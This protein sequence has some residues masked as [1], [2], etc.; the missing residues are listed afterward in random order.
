MPARWPQSGEMTK[1]VTIQQCV[2]VKNEFGEAQE[3]EDE[4][5]DLY[6]NLPA[7]VLATGQFLV[8]ADGQ[9]Q[10]HVL[11][12]IA[13]RWVPSIVTDLRALYTDKQGVER[14]LYFSGVNDLEQRKVW[15]IIS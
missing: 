9:V 5:T 4:W 13:I 7:R 12:E 11:W 14:Q 8:R 2:R 10:P 1:R 15:L 6:T 3:T